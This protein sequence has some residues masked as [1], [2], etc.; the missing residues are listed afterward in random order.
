VQKDSIVGD[1]TV[2]RNTRAFNPD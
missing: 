2:S 1:E